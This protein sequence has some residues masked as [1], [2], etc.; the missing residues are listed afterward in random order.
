MTQKEQA[1]LQILNSLLA[2]HMILNQAA[3]FV[4]VSAR[5]TRRMLAAYRE[6]GSSRTRSRSSWTTST[7]HDI[8]DTEVRSAARCS[9]PLLGTNHTHLSELLRSES[10]WTSIEPHCGAY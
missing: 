6:E 4:G 10:V 9:V 1:R 3:T 2:E 7:Q 8:G 5:H